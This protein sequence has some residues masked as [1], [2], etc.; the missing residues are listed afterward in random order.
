MSCL[1]SV[2]NDLIAQAEWVIP[3][4]GLA[5]GVLGWHRTSYGVFLC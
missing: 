4:Y 3:G 1:F 2:A 5:S